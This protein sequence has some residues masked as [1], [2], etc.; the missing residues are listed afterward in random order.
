MLLYFFQIMLRNIVH[1]GPLSRFADRKVELGAMAAAL[2]AAASRLSAPLVALDEGASQH[3][4]QVGQAPQERFLSSP[5]SVCRFVWHVCPTSYRTGLI[6][7]EFRSLV[8]SFFRIIKGADKISQGRE[9]TEIQK[10]AFPR[11]NISLIG[12]LLRNRKGA[13]RS[14]LEE[15]SIDSRYPT[16]LEDRKTLTAQRVKG[17][18]DLRPSQRGAATMCF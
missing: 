15:Q 1:L 18:R 3:G 11:F 9:R 8:N 12:P 2:G 5:E 7:T 14:S 4:G 10:G 13:H 16:G 17:M 6:L